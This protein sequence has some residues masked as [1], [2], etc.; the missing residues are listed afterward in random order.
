MHKIEFPF[1]WK[2]YAIESTATLSWDHQ[3]CF[4]RLSE[5]SGCCCS[6]TYCMRSPWAAVPCL[7]YATSMVSFWGK[8]FV[9]GVGSWHAWTSQQRGTAAI[10]LLLGTECKVV[11]PPVC[12]NIT[13][14][15]PQTC[16]RPHAASITLPVSSIHQSGYYP[17]ISKLYLAMFTVL[18]RCIILRLYGDFFVIHGWD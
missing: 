3:L 6:A 12:H 8:V 4:C 9:V 13:I 18:V 7:T 2:Q 1:F 16:C 10:R 15:Q 14:A 11:A 5:E 17:I